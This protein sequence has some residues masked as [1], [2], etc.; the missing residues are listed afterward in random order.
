VQKTIC[1]GL[2]EVLDHK[3]VSIYAAVKEILNEYGQKIEDVGFINT[4][5]A[6]ANLKAFR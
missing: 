3:A 5:N 4:D 6:S 2:K 1:L